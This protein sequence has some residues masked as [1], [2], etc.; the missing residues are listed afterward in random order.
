[1]KIP[2]WIIFALL[3]IAALAVDMPLQQFLRDHPPR[4]D[5]ARTLMLCEF[6]GFGWTVAMIILAVWILDHKHILDYRRWQVV[7]QLLLYAYGAGLV[8][9]LLKC[10]VARTRPRCLADFSGDVWSTFVGMPGLIDWQ[11]WTSDIQSFPS[12][13]SAT[14][15]GLAIGLGR[16]Y[17]RGKWLFAVYAAMACMQR[18]VA[19]A[20]FLS[21][22]I[23][24]AAVAVAMAS[25]I[26]IFLI[27]RT[28]QRADV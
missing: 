10:F 23:I 17:P 16:Y 14:A 5:V 8:A 22:V 1:M 12:G 27:P 18:V 9:N 21:D 3:A 4:G 6:F 13:H 15:V 19:E 7:P 25:L 26:E 24:G 2:V 11:L 20:H 28:W